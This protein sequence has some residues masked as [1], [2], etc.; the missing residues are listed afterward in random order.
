MTAPI[1]SPSTPLG[2]LSAEHFLSAIVDSSDDAIISKNLDG[3]IT[4]WNKSAE[5]IFGYKAEEII[6]KPVHIL[7]PRE[8]MEEEPAILARLR[9]GER[10]DH[11]ETKRLRK[12]GT[13][14]DISLTISPVK[15]D[16]GKIVGASKVARDITPQKQAAEAVS[17]AAE[18]TERQ[19]RMKD[20]FLA[21]LSHELR[22][23]LQSIS[24]WVQ[25]LRS[26]NCP[27]EDLVEGLEVIDRNVQAQQ[28]IIEDLMDMNRIL[29]GKVRLDV[30]PVDLAGLIHDAIAT[31]RPSA[32]SKDITLRSVLDPLAKS[33][34]G[35]PQRLQQILSNLLSNAIK[36][37]PNRGKVEVFLERVNS[38]LQ[39]TVSDT[40]IGIAAEFL[41]HVFE[42]FRQADAS[43][44]RS[45]GGLGLG[46]AIARH[47]S[48]LHGGRLSA[49]SPGLGQGSSFLLELPLPVMQVREVAPPPAQSEG[50]L[51]NSPN[52]EGL[53]ILVVDD[54]ED[55]RH[56]LA[57]TL[58][59][60]NATV[61][62][63][64]SADEALELLAARVPSVLISDIGM[65]G[66]NG[67]DL[68][69]AVRALPAEDGGRLPAIALTA[70]TRAEDRIRAMASGFQILVS[71]PVDALELLFTIERLARG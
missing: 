9:R 14:V 70:Y 38:H 47:L 50:A 17:K 23:P 20:E 40:G 28:R 8:R 62:T 57:K 31:I 69:A 18:E 55:S 16:S 5:R 52:L 15:D 7:I 36:F 51:P 44:R 26:G 37:T 12:D 67:H 24:G 4:S 34:M 41:P 68:V 63:A 25:I 71:K 64:R 10:V 29:S 30:Q 53:H 49:K 60:A 1:A 56:M 42:R 35:D 27:P 45:Q 54:D 6:G 48:E 46:L 61:T 59:R 11:F 65:P 33:V 22:T 39:V 21:M 13:I 43:D 32:V 58:T 3:I 19:S 2:F 66:K